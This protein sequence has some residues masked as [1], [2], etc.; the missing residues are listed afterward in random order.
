MCTYQV[1]VQVD[2]SDAGDTDREKLAAAISEIARFAAVYGMDLAA[3]A[4]AP[5]PAYYME[6]SGTD[7]GNAAL[8]KLAI[9]AVEWVKIL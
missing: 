7:K 8:F 3:M 9:A 6:A 4:N 1:T 5:E 2:T